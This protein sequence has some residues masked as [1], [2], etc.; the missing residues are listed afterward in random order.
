MAELDE[1]NSAGEEEEDERSA[2]SVGDIIRM[3]EAL[4]QKCILLID[5]GPHSHP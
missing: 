2:L 3:C 4:E 1:D 5:M